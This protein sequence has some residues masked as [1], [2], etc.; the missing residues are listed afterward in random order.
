MFMRLSGI[1]VYKHEATSSLDAESEKM[2]NRALA[3]I[4]S[5]KTMIIAAHRLSS[6]IG[7]DQCYVIENGEIVGAG[8]PSELHGNN[9]FY[10][11]LF[12]GQYSSE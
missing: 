2:I 5:Q 3:D 9:R 8:T 4:S 6:V 7:A 12:D 10:D 11:A 1:C